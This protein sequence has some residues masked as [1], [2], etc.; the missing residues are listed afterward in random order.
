MK[1]NMILSASG[2]RKVF[3]LS[4][5]E[6]DK[7][8]L[9]SEEDKALSVIAANVFCEYLKNKSGQENPVIAIGYDTR[10][11]G[12]SIAGAMLHALVAQNAIIQF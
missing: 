10:P 2:W 9:I 5:D 11:T 4:G 7:S 12:L 3:A 1:H 6:Q 8:P